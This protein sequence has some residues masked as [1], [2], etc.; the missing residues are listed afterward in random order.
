MVHRIGCLA[1]V[2]MLACS[3]F[4]QEC[5]DGVCPLKRVASAVVESPVVQAIAHRV[6]NVLHPV[7]SIRDRCDYQPVDL[8]HVVSDAA[9]FIQSVPVASPVVA[10]QSVQFVAKRFSTISV[11][12][13][14]RRYASWP[15][16][17]LRC[18]R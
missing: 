12:Q 13:S 9:P 17:A 4:G 18:R 15:V 11:A 10:S 16:R 2:L 3:G 7:D 8:V 5:R 14:V 6:D 1:F